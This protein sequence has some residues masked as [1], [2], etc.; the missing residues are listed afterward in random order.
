M[1]A[2][3][4]PIVPPVE[5]RYPTVERF[6]ER[7]SKEELASAFEGVRGELSAVKG[8]KVEHAKKAQAALDRAEELLSHL[9]DVRERLL[10]EQKAAKHR[11]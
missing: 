7:A 3:A 11:R 6:V 10:E 5:S 8:P 9:I 4:Q 1:S 2:P